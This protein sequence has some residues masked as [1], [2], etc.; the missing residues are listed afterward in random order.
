[1]I[2]KKGSIYKEIKGNPMINI[3]II[4]SLLF[5]LTVFQIP[6]YH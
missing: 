2:D 3:A 1:M 6:A 5:R 4:F